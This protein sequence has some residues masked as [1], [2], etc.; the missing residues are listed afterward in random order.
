[1]ITWGSQLRS[2]NT[3]AFFLNTRPI[4]LGEGEDGEPW[5]AKDANDVAHDTG[6]QWQSPGR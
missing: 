6:V 4:I 2:I 5:W 3:K 1:M